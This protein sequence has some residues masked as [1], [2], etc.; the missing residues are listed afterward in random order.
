MRGVE[1]VVESDRYCID[2][3]TRISAL[4]AALDEIALDLLGDVDCHSATGP[5]RR[6]RHCERAEHEGDQHE[7]PCQRGHAA[8]GDRL[9]PADTSATRF[10]PAAYYRSS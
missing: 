7:E 3:P 5:G 10:P 9:A 2:I 1:G 6:R 4:E 8:A